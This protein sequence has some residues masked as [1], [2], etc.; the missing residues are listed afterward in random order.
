MKNILKTIAFIF[1]LTLIFASCEGNNMQA[2]A[3]K[4]CDIQTKL[5]PLAYDLGSGAITAEEFTEKSQ[6]YTKEILD[7]EKKYSGSELMELGQM[8]LDCYE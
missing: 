4:I 5:E 8:I 7:L 1:T 6:K 3:Q 2:D